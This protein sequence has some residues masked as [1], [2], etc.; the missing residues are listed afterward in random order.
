MLDVLQKAQEIQR[1]AFHTGH[2]VDMKEHAFDTS[3]LL[4]NKDTSKVIFFGKMTKNGEKSLGAYK[5]DVYKWMWA[6]QEGF[7][8]E[9]IVNNL[10]S[11]IFIE[12]K[13]DDILEELTS[14]K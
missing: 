1:E 9:Q 12:I 14:Y 3:V 6:E 5:I 11:E 4:S 13:V 10:K 7:S 2:W 8:T